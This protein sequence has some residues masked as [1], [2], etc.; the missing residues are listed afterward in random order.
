MNRLLYLDYDVND[1]VDRHHMQ[2]F[3][4]NTISIIGVAHL[5]LLSDL[6]VTTEDDINK[7]RGGS[8]ANALVTFG[9]GM[10]NNPITILD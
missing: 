6:D 8:G 5:M 7:P 2:L 3:G 10:K 9:T 1:D 4:S